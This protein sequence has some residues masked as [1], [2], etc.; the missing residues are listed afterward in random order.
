MSVWR[1]QA[2]AGLIGIRKLIDWSQPGVKTRHCRGLWNS[3]F[4][5]WNYL[6][7]IN[8]SL[9]LPLLGC[10]NWNL[11][12][13]WGHCPYVVVVFPLYSSHYCLWRW[14]GALLASSVSLEPHP[15]AWTIHL[16]MTIIQTPKRAGM[17]ITPSYFMKLKTLIHWHS[18]KHYSR[19]NWYFHFH[20]LTQKSFQ[21][22]GFLIPWLVPCTA[23]HW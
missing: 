11:A 14:V 9:N 12:L 16:L 3:W 13:P 18:H 17:S 20:V 19:H 4:S 8:F 15:S 10:S 23:P 22:A 6:I 5:I 1:R 21:A 2:H 7:F